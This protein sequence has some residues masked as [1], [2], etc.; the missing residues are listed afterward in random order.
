MSMVENQ[1][2]KDTKE[3]E[4]LSAFLALVFTSWSTRATTT[5][6]KLMKARRGKSD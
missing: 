2:T 4:V 1:V 5:F 6:P 3:A